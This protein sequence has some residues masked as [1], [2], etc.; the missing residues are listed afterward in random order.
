M[1]NLQGQV[2]ALAAT[3]AALRSRQQRVEAR[4]GLWRCL[5]G[6]AVVVSLL[7]LPLQSG[8]AQGPSNGLDARVTALETKT[9]YVTVSGGQM[10]I[11]GTNL[12]VVN[13]LGATSQVN[14]LGNLIVGY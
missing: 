6:V 9:Q 3:L 13:G 14:G 10:I 7:I 12:H 5:A 1:E 8:K 2:A 11:T 4:L